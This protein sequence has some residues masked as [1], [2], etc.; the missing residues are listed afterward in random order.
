M[1]KLYSYGESLWQFINKSKH[2]RYLILSFISFAGIFI[3]INL[4]FPFRPEIEYS[5]LITGREGSPLRGFLT[6][7]DKWRFHTQ[8][9]EISEYQIKAVIEKEDKYFYYHPG[10]NLISVA[11][12]AAENIISGKIK[13]GA[14]TI[15]MQVVRL[16]ENRPRT[17]PNKVV[18]TFRALQLEL[19]YSKDQILEMYFNLVPYGGNIEGVKAASLFYFNKHP[20]Q[21]SL[22]EAVTLGIVP[23]KPTTMALGGNNSQ[24]K[25]YRNYWLE[26]FRKEKTFAPEMIDA[27]IGE[28]LEAERRPAPMIAPH[29]ALRAFEENYNTNIVATSIIPNLQR[30]ISSSVRDYIKRLNNHGIYNA[31]VIVI[32]NQSGQIA[33]YVGSQ[34]FS[35][36]ESQGQVDGI[37]ALRSPGSTLKPLIYALA[38][39]KGILTPNRKILDVPTDF[40]DYSPENFDKSYSGRVTMA[41]ALANSLNVPAVRTLGKI[42]VD[43]LIDRLGRTGFAHIRNNRKELGLSLALGGCGVTLQQLAGLYSAFANGGIYKPPTYKKRHG[44]PDTTRIISPEAAYIITRILTMPGRPDYPRNYHFAPSAVRIAWKTGTS[45]GRRDAW[46][47]GYNE[48]YTIGVWAGNFDGSHSHAL[49][50]ADVGT[51]LLF[52]LFRFAD[53]DGAQANRSKPENL[54][55]RKVCAETG[56]PPGPHCENKI[57]DLYIPLVS[58]SRKCEHIREIWV[59][60]N[61]TVSY[62]PQCLPPSGAKKKLYKIYP[63]E[64]IS[65]YNEN[66]IPFETVPPHNANCIAS[67]SAGPPKIL[68]PVDNLEYLIEKDSENRIMLKCAAAGDAAR[69]HWFA[70]N[71]LIVSAPPGENVF[72]RPR[73]EG[74]IE[75]K[76]CDDKGRSSSIIIFV[77]YY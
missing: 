51:P 75:I 24:L 77:K 42:G 46:S 21:L 2:V 8:L 10:I 28:R 11:R 13:S 31:S 48:K 39:D 47:I 43:T 7:G 69:V 55:P 53:P 34:D 22:A 62:C 49:T 14:S 72:Y 16:L 70:D 6:S 67:S 19:A 15:T 26:Y 3:I 60:S 33:A 63:P 37:S 65:Y 12:A 61:E 56:L 74:K 25:E 44:K 23:N 9:N 58:S 64:L 38:I 73:S 52:E 17:Y 5:K 76:C 4:L 1:K 68:N 45:Y 27:A 18:E 71:K 20:S 30:R 35:D 29:L 41:E 57:S 59:S 66:G 54:L 36:D 32:E 50:G 40:G